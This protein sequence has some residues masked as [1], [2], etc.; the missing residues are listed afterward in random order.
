MASIF[1]CSSALSLIEASMEGGPPEAPDEAPGLWACPI[2]VD[3]DDRDDDEE[4][5]EQSE[6]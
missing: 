1:C 5:E 6:M 3:D 2:E 4:E